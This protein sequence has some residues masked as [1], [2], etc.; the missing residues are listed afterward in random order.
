[1]DVSYMG[2]LRGEA[3][4]VYRR[5]RTE[6]RLAILKKALQVLSVH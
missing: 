6:A 4:A 3:L 5:K 1:V 2:R